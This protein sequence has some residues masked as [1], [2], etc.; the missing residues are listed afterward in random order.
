MK[1]SHGSRVLYRNQFILWLIVVASMYWN[2]IRGRTYWTWIKPCSHVTSTF[3]ST[4]K[5]P[6]QYTVYT[7]RK[8]QRCGNSAMTPAIL[9]SLKSMEMLENGLQPPSGA[10]LQSCRRI[11]ADTWCKQALKPCS[12]ITP[13]FAFASKVKNRVWSKKWWCSHLTFV[14]SRMG[15]QRSKK[16]I[17]IM[18]EW[19][20]TL[21][22]WWCKQLQ[23]IVL[24]PWYKRRC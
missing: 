9:F 7:K 8:R 1:V 21:H 18:C 14:F 24:S 5:L 23:R 12:H 16:S 17:D 13:A 22:Q 3:A 10:S 19:T 2:V 15:Q 11:D 20:S 6:S 4:S